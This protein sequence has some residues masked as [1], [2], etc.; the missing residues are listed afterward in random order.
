MRTSPSFAGFPGGKRARCG[1][2]A[3]PSKL[4]APPLWGEAVDGVNITFPRKFELLH[5]CVSARERGART[6]NNRASLNFFTVVF[7]GRRNFC[8]KTT[9]F[10]VTPCECLTAE[11]PSVRHA[12]QSGATMCN[13]L[14][15]NYESP[16]LTAELQARCS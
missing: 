15:L 1:W 8:C 4:N 2:G 11:L 9:Q 13:S 6:E 14:G 5:A 12:L 10:Y 3:L 16:A 7:Y